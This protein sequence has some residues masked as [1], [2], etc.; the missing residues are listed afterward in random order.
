MRKRKVE[1]TRRE[2]RGG[3]KLRRM[4][5]AKNVGGTEDYR[6]MRMGRNSDNEKYRKSTVNMM[7]T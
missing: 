7:D 2:Q 1:D 5:G 4:K 3:K 6:A